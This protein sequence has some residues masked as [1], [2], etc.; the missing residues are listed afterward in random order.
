[1]AQN[2]SC[3]F[4]LYTLMPSLIIVIA[5]PAMATV[6]IVVTTREASRQKITASPLAGSALRSCKFINMYNIYILSLIKL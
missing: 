4:Q 6:V 3:M 5:T 2:T 1:M